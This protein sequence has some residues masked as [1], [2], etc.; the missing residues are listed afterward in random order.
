MQTS[1]GDLTIPV[2]IEDLEDAFHAANRDQF[3]FTVTL[4]KRTELAVKRRFC[5]RINLLKRLLKQIV[6][7]LGSLSRFFR[8]WSNSR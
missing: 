1:H 4:M 6:Q 7:G 5:G 2:P 8:H 3:S